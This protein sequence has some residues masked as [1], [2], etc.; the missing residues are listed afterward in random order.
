MKSQTFLFSSNYLWPVIWI[1]FF[2]VGIRLV[3]LKNQCCQLTKSS[4]TLLQKIVKKHLH[5]QNK[6]HCRHF[7]EILQ[8]GWKVQKFS[9]C[10][11]LS[12]LMYNN[13]ELSYF[14]SKLSSCSLVTKSLKK[15]KLIKN[16]IYF[17]VGRIFRL[18]SLK[19]LPEV[20]NRISK[21]RPKMRQ[22]WSEFFFLNKASKAS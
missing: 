9:F 7:V 21:H 15:W 22:V 2:I 1:H 6:M 20:G 14:L 10:T 16:R 5:V 3:Y 11:L 12:Q 4:A 8:K 19:F 18:T 13:L 17:P